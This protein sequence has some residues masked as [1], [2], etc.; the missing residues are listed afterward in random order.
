MSPCTVEGFKP[1]YSTCR[2]VRISSEHIP[3][4]VCLSLPRCEQS[5][6]L[7]TLSPSTD[8][9]ADLGLIVL[10]IV[11]SQNIKQV[12]SLVPTPSSGALPTLV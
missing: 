7:S 2:C 5:E 12:D 10:R 9:P 6:H 8:P 4:T 1:P 11:Y 3:A